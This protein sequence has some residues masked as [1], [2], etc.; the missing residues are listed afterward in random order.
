VL[1]LGG[2]SGVAGD[3][4]R[5]LRM[6]ASLGRA[7]QV[8]SMKPELKAPGTILFKLGCDEPLSSF[9]FNFNVRRYTSGTRCCARTTSAGGPRG[10]APANPSAYF[11]AG[12]YTRS[13]FS[14][15]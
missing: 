13:L 11:L 2:S 5:Y 14:S 12:A 15:S 8:E 9:A 1:F 10:C 4:L 7:V 6:L 3:T